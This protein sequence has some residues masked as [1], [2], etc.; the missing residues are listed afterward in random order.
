MAD[1]IVLSISLLASNRPDTIRKCLDS[2]KP[3]MEQIPSELILVDTSGSESMHQILQ[4]YTDQVIPFTWCNDFSKARNAGLK[5]AKGE[6][7]LFLDDDEWFVEID[8]LVRFF[9]SGDYRSYTCAN[10]IVRNFYDKAYQ[11]Y[12]DS[13]VSRMVRL[14]P[15]TEFR[16]K[17]HE[18]LYPAGT[19]CKSIPA[20]AYH[21][22]YIYDSEEDKRKHFERNASLLLD[23]IEEE[24]DNLR[25][26]V[27]L[28]QEYRSIKDWERLVEFCDRC[29]EETRSLNNKYDNYDIGTFYAGKMESL[30]F[31]K[32]YDEARQVGEDAMKD[33]RN[34]LLC[35]AYIDLCYATLYF[36]TGDHT[37]A[38]DYAHRYLRVGRR[39]RKDPV[40]L[41]DQK[42]ALL[43]GE[44][45]D[46]V[47]M[48]RVYSILIACGLQRGD[49]KPLQKYLRDLEWNRKVI[50]VFD[51]MVDVIVDAAAK[52]GPEESLVEASQYLW[53]N[54]QTQ[55]KYFVRTQEWADRPDG[56]Q[57]LLVVI[58]KI[59]SEHW[60]VYYARVRVA[61]REKCTEDIAGELTA[62]YQHC[63]NVFMTPNEI[64]EIAGEY[65]VNVEDLYLSVD[66]DRWKDQI[67][68]YIERVTLDDLLI[69]EKEFI[70]RKTKESPYY[71]FL[72]LRIAE[73]KAISLGTKQEMSVKRDW[74][75]QF[76]QRAKAYRNRYY[77]QA[78][79]TDYTELLPEDLQASIYISR[80]LEEEE[81]DLRESLKSY[82]MAMELCPSFAEAMK[83]YVHSLQ[84]DHRQ[85]KQRQ[86]EEMYALQQQIKEE[87]EKAIDAGKSADAYGILTELK[88]MQPDDLETAELILKARLAM[89]E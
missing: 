50:Y 31:L 88:K 76:E 89:L 38:E 54:A 29:L 37:K 25:W 27:Q 79:L 1:Q 68:E 55:P 14:E 47:P 44:A 6:W 83:N 18:Y 41:E 74:L 75:M 64:L 63:S 80:G 35:E 81:K 85:R 70:N 17:I 3:I 73:A 30:L 59:K 58:A 56:F 69:T 33:P 4:E 23:M 61:D 40:G 48:K 16:S 28:A 32:R 49:L 65:Q 34:S 82:K 7:F 53:D 12:S 13:W 87:A 22:G 19:R 72:F 51:G 8:P 5:R 43:V 86:K 24:P 15:G 62:F 36:R 9:K 11:N 42:T 10:Y 84:E 20:I 57:K 26:K 21:S 66:F 39:L 78:V 71:D 60:Y 52:F 77:Q 67:S 45:L 2:L 46:S